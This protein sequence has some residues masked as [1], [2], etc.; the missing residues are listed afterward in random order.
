MNKSLGN[1]L[2]ITGNRIYKQYWKNSKNKYK[3]VAW[4]DRHC[5]RCGRFL[6]KNTKFSI[7]HACGDKHI[8]EYKHSL[9]YR[10]QCKL[11]SRVQYN[12]NRFNVGDIL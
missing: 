5:T 2:I 9:E 7:C 10:E 12:P 4:I 3:L 11:R 1:S 6:L 8:Y